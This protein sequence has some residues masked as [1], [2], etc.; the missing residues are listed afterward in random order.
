MYEIRTFRS[1]FTGVVQRQLV[2]TRIPED[3]PCIVARHHDEA[4]W[5]PT[6]GYTVSEVREAL[7]SAGDPDTRITRG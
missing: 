3:G 2:D 4:G 1:R 6:R 7:A 5:W